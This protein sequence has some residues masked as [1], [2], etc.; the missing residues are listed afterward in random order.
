MT[1]QHLFST[2]IRCKCLT[3]RELQVHQDLPS[4]HLSDSVL[5][6]TARRLRA[7]YAGQTD[8]QLLRAVPTVFDYDK[9]THRTNTVSNATNTSSS[10]GRTEDSRELAVH[11][12]G[13][14]KHKKMKMTDAIEN[15]TVPL[16]PTEAAMIKRKHS[17]VR[18]SVGGKLKPP[19]APVAVWEN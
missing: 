14:K 10:A 17:K 18:E 15:A 6:R 9:G 12:E 5:E 16:V 8:A 4:L 3:Q 13:P 19:V 7:L 2:F 1:I 11:N